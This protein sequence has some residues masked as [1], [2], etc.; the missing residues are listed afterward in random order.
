[1]HTL[2]NFTKRERICVGKPGEEPVF[3][4]LKEMKSRFQWDLETDQIE[5]VDSENLQSMGYASIDGDDDGR[6]TNT[7]EKKQDDGMK[8]EVFL[9]RGSEFPWQERSE[10]WKN[11]PHSEDV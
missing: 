2:V 1:M 7:E 8:R 4:I 3:Q 10:L 6:D 9:D 11:L 5:L